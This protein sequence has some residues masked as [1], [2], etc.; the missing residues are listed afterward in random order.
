MEGNV[1]KPRS[2]MRSPT[3][4]AVTNWLL[5]QRTLRLVTVQGNLKCTLKSESIYERNMRFS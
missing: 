3:R 2:M 1:K 5:I 4:T